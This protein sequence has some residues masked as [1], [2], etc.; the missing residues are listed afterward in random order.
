MDD[1]ERSVKKQIGD[2]WAEFWDG[3]TQREKTLL[4]WGGLVA[5]IALVYLVLWA[6]AYEGR[7]RLR[8]SLPVMQRQLAQMTAQA[9]EARSLSGT[10]EGVMPT[11]GALKDALAKSLADNGMQAAQVQ[12]IGAAVQIQLKNASFPEWTMWLD[13]VRKLYKVQV[14]EAHIQA[15]KPDGQVDL[16]ASLQPASP[17]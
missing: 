16:T 13:D 7:A 4:M 11:G 10:V 15:L 9:N 6:P 1:Q 14:A 8:E 2:L 3:R 17:K 5:A 12:V